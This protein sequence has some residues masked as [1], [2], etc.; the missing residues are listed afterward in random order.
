[1]KTPDIEVK[2]LKDGR[3]L[4]KSPSGQVWLSNR[5][6]AIHQEHNLQTGGKA[7]FKYAHPHG[8]CDCWTGSYED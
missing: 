2:T 1:M 6:A 4:Y 8:V 5:E 3:K 7:L